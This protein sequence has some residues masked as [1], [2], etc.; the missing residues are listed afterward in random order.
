MRAIL[1]LNSGSSSLKLG[2]FSETL[3]TLAMAHID[4]LGHPDGTLKV[5]D[6]AGEALPVPALGPADLASHE[7]ALATAL[8]AFR[9]DLPL[10][11]IVAV[12]HRIVHGG[13]SHA[14][15][16][17]VSPALL[18]ELAALTPFAPLHQPHNLRGV[19][20]AIAAFPG[21][22]NYLCYDTAFHRGHPFVAD[23]YALPR[24]YF[25]KGVRRYG[26][27]G[28]SYGYIDSELAE[29]EPA[30]RAGR[31][32]V[33][34]LGSGASVCAIRGGQ[35]VA[36][37]MGFS[38]LSGLPMGTRAGELDAGVVLYLMEQEGMSLAEVT[39][40]LFKK[41][42]LFGM[43]G[44]SNDM[45]VLEASD[46]AH[47]HEA[48][49]YFCFRVAR[50]IASM[51]AAMGGIDGLVFTGGIG[52][53]SAHARA[54]ICEGLGW[55]GIALNGAANAAHAREISSGAVAVRVIPTNEEIMIARAARLVLS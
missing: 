30:L 51:A 10:L 55:M 39:E 4:R 12:G 15:P 6:G 20:A 21:V 36:S 22:P 16:E 44:L 29:S 27:H 1:T 49:D 47:A 53:H 34:H 14:A 7:A 43:S 35:S 23:T 31:V 2:L 26:F 28:L 48:I 52:E 3:D 17:R 37:S 9:I 5:K 40:L 13:T 25:E 33:A 11:E 50:E 38:T 24:A 54:Q 46:S 18:E 32:V 45:R 8:A 19:E 42:G 41:S